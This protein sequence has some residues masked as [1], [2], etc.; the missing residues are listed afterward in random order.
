[1][2]LVF[3]K[4]SRKREASRTEPEAIGRR[5]P[6]PPPP[7]PPPPVAVPGRPLA[8]VPGRLLAAVPGRAPEAVPKR[9]YADSRRVVASVVAVPG[10]A[11]AVPGRG[12]EAFN[13]P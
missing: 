5:S 11:E 4:G 9:V 7:P 6:P 1:M 3:K 12:A 2:G 13:A 8:A 10:L